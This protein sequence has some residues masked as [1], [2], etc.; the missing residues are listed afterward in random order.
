MNKYYSCEK[1]LTLKDKNGK[2]PDIYIADGNRTAGKSVSF[3]KKLVDTFFKKKD[4]NQFFYIYRYKT[5]MNN[6]SDSFFSDIGRLFYNGHVMTEKKIFDG[7]M[8]QL[9]IDSVPCG[10]CIPLSMAS[11]IKRASALFTQVRHGFF[12]EYQ[13]EDNKYLD[14]EIEKLMSIHTTIARGDGK[15]HR[16]VPLYMASNT[17]SIINPYYSALGINKSLK[18]NTKI[19]KGDG[20]VYER[21]YNE[22]AQKSFEN[23]GFNRA[24]KTTKYFSYASQ[25][26]YLNDNLSLIDKPTG[27]SQ[28]FVTIKYNLSWFNVR[29]YDTCYYVSQGA[30][31]TFPLRICFNVNDV[32]DDRTV[33]V[34]RNNFIVA[35]LRE[36]FNRGLLR[37]QDVKC[38]NMILDLLAYL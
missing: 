33:K 30:D 27:H 31:E 34:T 37:F 24:F 7:A 38:K 23:A 29:R 8:V 12:D 5:D 21:T 22:S 35:T 19:L 28:Y 16:R 4:V 36:Y 11:K 17:V 26:V 2:L 15:Q 18:Y 25:N 3:K 1:L 14:N 20:W 13:D 6:V 10:F 32:T 9:F